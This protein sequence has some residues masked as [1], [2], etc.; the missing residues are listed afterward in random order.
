MNFLKFI[1]PV[2]VLVACKDGKQDIIKKVSGDNYKY[3]DLRSSE[4]NEKV[5]G[6]NL[7]SICYY[8][9]RKGRYRIYQYGKGGRILF[10]G[11]DVE[12]SEMWSYLSDSTIMIAEANYKIEKLTN[13]TFIY[14]HPDFGRKILL[15]SQNQST[16]FDTVVADTAGNVGK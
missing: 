14:F 13:D 6:Q 10:D 1:F 16:S 3:W 12:I 4:N 5:L 2:V 8:F 15:R 11:G 7:D 9:D